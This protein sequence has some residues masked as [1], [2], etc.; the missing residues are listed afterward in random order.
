M[1]RN[2]ENKNMPADP[3]KINKATSPSKAIQRNADQNWGSNKGTTDP[4]A[5]IDSAYN[6]HPVPVS[7]EKK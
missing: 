3:G 2:K 4:K 5:A 7:G 6:K 1:S